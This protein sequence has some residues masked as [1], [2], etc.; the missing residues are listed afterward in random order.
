LLLQL[1]LRI[2]RQTLSQLSV[3]GNEVHF[4][5][6]TDKKQHPTAQPD[7]G[8]ALVYVIGAAWQTMLP[9]TLVRR[10]RDSALMAHG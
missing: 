10:Q 5:V 7:A 9:S 1:L 8:K 4:D 3:A 2:P 6:K